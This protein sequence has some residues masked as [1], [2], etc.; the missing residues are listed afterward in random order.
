MNCAAA[1]VWTVS[2]MTYTEA[3][4]AAP[5]LA[6]TRDPAILRALAQRPGL[7]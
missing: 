5:G 7:K 4:V 3:L 2:K 1:A 6:R